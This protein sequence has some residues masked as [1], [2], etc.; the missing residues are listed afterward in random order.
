MQWQ[1]RIGKPLILTEV[2]YLSQ[3]DAAAWP[4]K[5][6]ADEE[7]NLEIQRRC[8]EAVRTVWDKEERLAG[9]YF[10]NWFGWGGPTSKEYTP[11]NKPA[12]AEV[13]LW[14]GGR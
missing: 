1:S 5:E 14:Y 2:G 7:L 13:G 8:Y 12:A 10:W 3:T 11:R 4:W 6:G 9:I